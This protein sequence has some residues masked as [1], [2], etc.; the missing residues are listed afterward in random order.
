MPLKIWLPSKYDL[1][2]LGDLLQQEW[3]HYFFSWSGMLYDLSIPFLLLWKRTRLLAFLLVIVFHA[4]TRV[5]FPIG[6]FPYIMILSALIFF[7][8][9]LHQRILEWI[10]D[11]LRLP[12]SLTGS[13]E[14][15]RFSAFRKKLNLAVIGC[16][17]LFQLL[18][19][20]R[21]LLYPGELFWTEEGYRF[22]WR[23]MLMEKAG[24]AQFRIV[25]GKTGNRLYI[26]NSDIL[27]PFQEKQMSFQPDFILQYAH[28]LAEHFRKQGHQNIE[29]YVDSHVALNGRGSAP[30]ISPEVNLLQFRESMKPKTFL[31]PFQDEIKGL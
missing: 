16:F 1:P 19:P 9:Q 20:W 18:F 15:F 10:S 28:Y 29:V 4:L 23:V 8:P 11:R 24:H 14:K 13:S 25:D 27:T 5:L 30:Y 31:L 7:S 22:S 17:F 26:D 6:M 3:V 21:Y 2:L 12:G